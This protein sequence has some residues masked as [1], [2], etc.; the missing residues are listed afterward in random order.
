MSSTIRNNRDQRFNVRTSQERRETTYGLDDPYQKTY[1][2]SF[3]AHSSD[4]TPHA[5]IS[6]PSDTDHKIDHIHEIIRDQLAPRIQTKSANAALS[7]RRYFFYYRRKRTGRRCGCYLTET[8]PENQCPICIG[9]GVVGGYDKFGTITEILDYTT[10][11]L[12]MVNVEPNY[13]ED[14]RPVYLKLMDGKQS[15][16]AEGILP[17]KS[18][19]KQV[20]NFMLYQPIFNKGTKIIATCPLGNSR[21]IKE[22][23]DFTPFLNFDK[24]KIRIEF[25]KVDERPIVSHFLLRYQIKDDLRI[26]GDIP[27]SEQE[28]TGT[29]LGQFEMYQEIGIFFPYRPVLKYRNEDVLYRCSDGRM[30]KIVMVKEN[31]VANVLTSTDVRARYLIRDIDVGVTR[32]LLV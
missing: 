5:F 10:P 11:N 26:W 28:P 2:R 23:E 9:T 13:A 24:V 1:D 6:E 18:N 25:N 22:R 4:R 3:T 15:G 8:S 30:F 20:D 16:Y 29:E 7:D 31:I 32:H 27:Q 17:I 19:I 14:T 12:I 21:E